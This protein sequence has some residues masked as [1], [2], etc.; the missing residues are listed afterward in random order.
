MVAAY[1]VISVQHA[2]L[3]LSAIVCVCTVMQCDE[4]VC[5]SLLACT[6]DS[7]SCLISFS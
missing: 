6:F 1:L 3:L 2:V 5:E 4:A 7:S